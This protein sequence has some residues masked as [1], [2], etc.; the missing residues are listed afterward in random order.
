[1]SH[2]AAAVAL[3]AS[4]HE[5]HASWVATQRGR[6]R[7]GAICCGAA[8]LRP[9]IRLASPS[10]AAGIVLT[11][12][13]S[14]AQTSARIC[15]RRV[16]AVHL[17]CLQH[18]LDGASFSSLR[19]VLGGHGQFA[20]N[21]ARSLLHA[22]VTDV[23]VHGCHDALDAASSNHLVFVGLAGEVA[24]HLASCFLDADVTW[25][26]HHGADDRLN[27]AACRRLSLVVAVH[28]Q[29]AQRRGAS[30]LNGLV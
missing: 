16:V 21:H 19:L 26:R 10:L 18:S 14:V 25:V 28:R 13:A 30:L 20:E 29:V 2:A 11:T 1:L 15:D 23:C 12:S 5:R 9:L 7:K 22:R 24:Q 27:A 8:L 4:R 3:N 6:D 17:E